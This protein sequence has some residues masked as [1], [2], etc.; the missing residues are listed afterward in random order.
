MDN[1]IVT[2]N[3]TSQKRTYQKL[4]R[5]IFSG[6]KQSKTINHKEHRPLLKND[7]SCISFRVEFI[8]L[9]F[10]VMFYGG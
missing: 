1:S 2:M 7:E 8:I 6:T 4:M 5:E 10:E 9:H 3:V